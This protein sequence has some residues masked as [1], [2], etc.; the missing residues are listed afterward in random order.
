VRAQLTDANFT[1]SHLTNADFR[2]AD[3]RRAKL[4]GADL[5]HAIFDKADLSNADLSG[6]DITGAS[7]RGANLEGAILKDLGAWRLAKDMT[8]MRFVSA[9]AFPDGFTK[10][11][12]S[13]WNAIDDFNLAKS[14]WLIQRDQLQYDSVG[15]VCSEKIVDNL[16][17]AP[18][19]GYPFY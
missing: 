14:D 18:L 4:V 8:G 11:V 1:Q 12:R 17:K 15:H 16:D 5:S 2:S 13:R 6:A 19:A 10:E 9:R 7:F 3:L